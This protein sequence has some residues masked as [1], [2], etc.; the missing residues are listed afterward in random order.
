MAN[1]ALSGCSLSLYAGFSQ[2]SLI[3]FRAI[4]R[5]CHPIQMHLSIECSR[6][7]NKLCSMSDHSSCMVYVLVNF[8]RQSE[9]ERLEQF[10]EAVELWISPLG[11][12]TVKVF[13]IEARLTG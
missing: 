11:Q 5:N 9:T 13:T 4:I 7:G 12:Y 10:F 8:H 6:Y 1:Q 3:V 2:N